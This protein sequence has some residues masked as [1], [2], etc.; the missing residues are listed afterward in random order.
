[1]MQAGL[2]WKTKVKNQPD[3]MVQEN[4]S[5]YPVINW[6]YNHMDFNNAKNGYKTSYL[7]FALHITL[8][9][10]GQ[11]FNCDHFKQCFAKITSLTILLNQIDKIKA[12]LDSAFRDP[13]KSKEEEEIVN[14]LRLTLPF[15]S[16]TLKILSFLIITFMKSWP[17]LKIWYQS[18]LRFANFGTH[19][20]NFFE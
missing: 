15:I 3:F 13:N 7:Q 17:S 11:A 9:P 14:N 5:K 12:K 4:G 19:L 10:R 6:C 20:L 2:I 1:M 8:L 18:K 16:M